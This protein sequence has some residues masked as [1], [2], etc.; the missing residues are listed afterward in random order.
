MD[1]PQESEREAASESHPAAEAASSKATKPTTDP[2]PLSRRIARRTTD[3]L[4]IAILAIGL[5]TV[6][7][8]IS[9]WWATTEDDLLSST[10]IATEV[11]GQPGNWNDRGV[12]IGLAS[13]ELPVRLERLSFRGDRD[14]VDGIILKR[15]R[16][17]LVQ[18]ADARFSSPPDDAERRLLRL[19]PQIEPVET[20]GKDG[21]V[22]RLDEPGTQSAI[23]TFV[24]CRV[25]PSAEDETGPAG[26]VVCWAMATP[27][28]ESDWRVF[29]FVRST[30]R[31]GRAG[32]VVLP[33]GM[34]IVFS[35]SDP[36]GGTLTAITSDPSESHSL[37]HWR[38][39]LERQLASAGWQRIRQWTQSDGATACRFQQE[40][41][42]GLE[43]IEL[44]L[45]E[46]DENSVTGLISVTPLPEE[47]DRSE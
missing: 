13:A 12:P 11:A 37:E 24:A 10:E 30:Q 21:R 45:R 43:A 47:S 19:L 28:D 32:S 20:T 6:S 27:F 9:G 15:L 44:I 39:R 3:L 2:T 22:Y 31:G 8:Q 17:L 38:G 36:A 23:A 4:A 16:Q 5:L 41:E 25:T 35:L 40:T 26:R 7:G 33:D 14:Q 34:R 46:A 18:T 29:F 1:T 42:S